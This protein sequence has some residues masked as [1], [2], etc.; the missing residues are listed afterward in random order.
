MIRESSESRV[1]RESS[2]VKKKSK[3]NLS[4]LF[5][6]GLKKKKKKAKHQQNELKPI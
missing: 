2:V 6:D 3:P 4:A 1:V 5:A